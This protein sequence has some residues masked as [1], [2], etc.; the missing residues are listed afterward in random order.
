MPSII[1]FLN[2]VRESTGIEPEEF[3]KVFGA[4]GVNMNTEIPAEMESKMRVLLAPEAAKSNV[5]IKAH[6]R[7]QLLKSVDDELHSALSENEE[8]LKKVQGETNSYKK[9]PLALKLL[10]DQHKAAL[11]EAGKAQGGD[12]S[13]W[14]T[15]AEAL[16]REVEQINA[17]NASLKSLHQSQVDEL[18]AGFNQQIF[19]R[20]LFQRFSSQNYAVSGPLTNTD[21][22][23]I[24][25]DKFNSV[26]AE[27]GYQVIHDTQA[28]SF[29]LQTKDGSKVF[30]E[31]IPVKFDDLVERTAKEYLAKK[32]EG[33]AAP[34]TQTIK[35]DN[36]GP[37][38]TP[39][40][41][42]VAAAHGA[43]A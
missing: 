32:P 38:M 33:N 10:Q 13:E 7:G 20:D 27:K 16:Q 36:Q 34:G 31:N 22:A 12:D 41:R 40:Q 8:L 24:V 1:N 39:Y 9:G 18:N 3:Q 28:G 37:N 43:Q 21:M 19:E 4:D 29:T 26:V 42:K 11:E 6:F 2:W 35:V 17:D 14:K 23:K 5:D 25:R 15:K 30:E